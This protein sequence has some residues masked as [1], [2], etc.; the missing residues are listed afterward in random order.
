[1]TKETKIS[2]FILII[3]I[4]SAV[5]YEFS[6]ELTATKTVE[7]SIILPQNPAYLYQQIPEVQSYLNDLKESFDK[8]RAV[9]PLENSELDSGGQ[10]VQEILLKN[11]QFLA[12]TQRDGKLL[13]N[14][15]MSIRP[16]IVSVLNS[17][18]QVTCQSHSCYQ[19]EKYNFATNATTRAIVDVVDK[20]VLS[21]QQYANTQAD[22]N[23][24]LT[25][26]AQQIALNAPEIKQ[27]LKYS[28]AIKDMTMANVRAGL[29][30]SPCENSA[31]LCVAPTFADHQ[32]EQSLWA[33]IDLTDLKLVA[34]KW[35]GLGKTT[36]PACISER[37]LQNRAIMKNYCQQDTVLEKNSWQFIYR[38]TGS[39]GLEIRDASFKG[40]KVLSSAKIVDW[41]VSYQQKKGV[42]LDTSTKTVI[43]GRT[44]EYDKDEDNNYFFGYNDAMGCPMFST[45]VVLPFNGP[46]IRDLYDSNKQVIGF[47]IVQDFRNAKWPMACNYRYENRFE[48]YNDGSFRVVGIN[49]GRGCG[50][51]AVYRPVMRIDMAVDEKESFYQYHQNQWR[52]WKQEQTGVTNYGRVDG[53]FQ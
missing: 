27:E 4:V 51:N 32:K 36:T 48:F 52:Q 3:G 26:I 33:I 39:D 47:Y 46:Q 53:N 15:M 45:S 7:E 18:E 10:Q 17:E 29:N 44:V 21:V 25:R 9:L 6:D 49:I 28:P 40:E 16:A 11:A 22:I 20:K 31:H 13:H 24:R 35:A 12:D 38:L 5:F 14:D 30:G 42:T 19:A 8:G 37:S 43:A 1:M 41:H 34:A 2:L 50:N 23:L